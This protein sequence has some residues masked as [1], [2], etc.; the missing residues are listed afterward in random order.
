MTM[1]GPVGFNEL[2]ELRWYASGQSALKGS[3]LKLS[4]RIDAL[5]L[6]WAD[7]CNAT[8]YVFPPFIPAEDLA[9]LDYFRSFPH[10]VTFPVVLDSRDTNLERFVESEQIDETGALR[11]SALAPVRDVL[12]PAACY[13]FYPT[14]QGETLEHPRYVTTMATCFRREEQYVPL[15]RQWSFSMREIVCFGTAGEVKDFLAQYRQRIDKTFKQIGLPINWE[16][17]TDPFFNPSKSP[18]YL[19]QKLDP[20]KTEMMFQD[21]LAI[22]SINFHRNYFGEAFDISRDGKDAFSGCVAFGI[23]RWIFAWLAQFGT[24]EQNWPE[25][26]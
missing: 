2:S 11:L 10:L 6:S 8:E 5:F 24:K 25:L 18:K 14:F 17:A 22:G 3:L 19:L 1:E 16:D 21:R 13:H 7:Q 26:T 9:K 12:T 23:E 15:E 4:R 20:V